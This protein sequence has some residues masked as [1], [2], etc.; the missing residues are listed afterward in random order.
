MSVDNFWVGLEKRVGGA[1]MFC[2]TG[3]KIADGG[4][5]AMPRMPVGRVLNGET[6]CGRGRASE[7]VSSGIGS[8][9]YIESVAAV[10]ASTLL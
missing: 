7:T 9:G 6:I 2:L 1:D 8:V 5:L 3:V 10:L 4:R